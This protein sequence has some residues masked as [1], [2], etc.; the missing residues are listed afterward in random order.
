MARSAESLQTNPA[1]APIRDPARIHAYFADRAN[2]RDIEAL[3]AAYEP[4]AIIV[5]R[6][7]EL[8]VGSQAVWAHLENLLSMK[9]VMRIVGSKT[10]VSGDLAQL[11]SHWTGDVTMPDGTSL[12]MESTGSELARRQPDGTWRVVIDNPWGAG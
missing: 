9:P 11:S 10:V 4:G 7:G 3:H 5:E 12:H 8:S 6:N 2:A 1:A